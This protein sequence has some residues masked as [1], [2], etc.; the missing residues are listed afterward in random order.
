MQTSR[1]TSFYLSLFKKEK[2][3]TNGIGKYAKICHVNKERNKMHTSKRQGD[4]ISLNNIKL[5]SK[6]NF[7]WISDS[8]YLA[9]RKKYIMVVPG[10]SKK[11]KTREYLIRFILNL[12]NFC[13]K[14]LSY[15]TDW[16]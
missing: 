9:P 10:G 1:R 7:D 5:L 11:E 16:F 12:L 14:K 3:I 2:A 15:F 4:Q 13:K 8:N 6:N